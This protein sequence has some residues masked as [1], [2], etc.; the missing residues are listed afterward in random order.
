MLFESS[1]RS[2]SGANHRIIPSNVP[3]NIGSTSDGTSSNGAR[4]C[5]AFMFTA[6]AAAAFISAKRRLKESA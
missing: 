3:S 2:D 1:A 5:N 4:T 6:I